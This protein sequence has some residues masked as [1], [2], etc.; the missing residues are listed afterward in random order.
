MPVD[1]ID[2]S[3]G[4]GASIAVE[5][6]DSKSYIYDKMCF[7][8]VDTVTLV[9]ASVGSGLPIEGIAGGTAVP[10]SGTVTANAGTGTFAVDGSGFTQPVSG[11]VT[12]DAG[13]GFPGLGT[14][15]SAHANVITVQGIASG[16]VL[17]VSGTVTANAGTGNFAITA[18]SLPLPTGAAQSTDLPGLG[19]AG[20]A[21]SNVITV[22]G[23]ASMTPLLATVT[24][25]GTFAVQASIA[26]A[27]TLAAVT[28]IT[29]TV[30]VDGTGTF[31][32]QAACTINAGQTL[33][34]VTD[35]TNPVAVTNTGTFAVQSQPTPVATG[36]LTI[37]RLIG[38]ATTNATSVKASAGQVYGAYV[39]NV[40]ASPVFLKLY[41]KASAPT[42]GTDTPVMTLLIPGNA[43]GVA[44]AFEFSMGIAF[45]TG[46][47]FAIT[48]LVADADTTAVA[49]NE[50]VVHLFYK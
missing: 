36:G 17:P 48:G 19:T 1:T 21:D 29:N 34:A 45:A 6:V 12:A 15:G 14:A 5:T 37:E 47:A 40:N 10:I 50:Q 42:V 25:A 4:T 39:S 13:T 26:S 24:N 41:N 3:P 23:I 49:A 7:G 32:V 46:I 22:Q 11:T 35:I 31:A 20:S 28:D 2:V 33:A 18:A 43:S 8:A 9:A 27:Q 30:T 38:A 44:G 16:T